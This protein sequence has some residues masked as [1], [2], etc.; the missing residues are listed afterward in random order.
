MKMKAVIV[1]GGAVGLLFAAR[2][3]QQGIEVCV[4]VRRAEQASRLNEHGVTLVSKA[5]SLTF[6]V[7]AVQLK[8]GQKI[9]ADL[10]VVAVKQYHLQRLSEMIG[11]YLRSDSNVL[12]LQNGMS[13]LEMMASLP[14]KNVYVGV[15]EHGALKRSD[16]RIEHTGQGMLKLAAYRGSLHACEAVWRK[17][18]NNDFPL[19]VGE[20]WYNLL[21]EKLLV[22]AVINPLTALYRVANGALIA[23]EHF[24]KTMQ[25]LFAEAY[26]VLGLPPG[27][28]EKLW[29]HVVGVCRSTGNN[30]SSM[31]RDIEGGGQTEIGA[32]SGYVLNRAK[33]ARISLPYTAFV[34]ESILGLETYHGIRV[35]SEGEG[36]ID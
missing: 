15:V 12:F 20:D 6:P 16:N 17:V 19:A 23:N 26:D 22:N 3:A 27:E 31:L 18:E 4:Q 8:P 14:C 32:I 10:I 36:R 9:E 11:A 28:R 5:D 21:A 35:Q 7:Q 1:G 30:R 13:H 29:R 2:F 25:Q 24:M 34:Y 33:M